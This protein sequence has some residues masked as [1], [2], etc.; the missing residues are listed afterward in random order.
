M[1]GIRGPGR[2][3]PPGRDPG[4]DLQAPEPSWPPTP[5]SLPSHAAPAHRSAVSTSP[6]AA[7]R[8]SSAPCSPPHSPHCALTPS[9]GPTTGTNAIKA[10]RLGLGR[11]RLG[12]PSHPDPARHDPQRRPQQPTAINTA[13]RS[14][15]TH[16]IGAPSRDDFA[17]P[18][19]ISSWP[20]RSS[21][22]YIHHAAP[23]TSSTRLILKNET[24]KTSLPMTHSTP[25]DKHII[26]RYQKE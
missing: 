10:N 26:F 15:L 6:T 25:R 12:P 11:P 1:P 16:H 7:T 18:L 4:Q 17:D 23:T 21:S 24:Q 14:R 3:R 13:T 5:G 20:Q 22:L 8:G 19:T 9:P 2:R